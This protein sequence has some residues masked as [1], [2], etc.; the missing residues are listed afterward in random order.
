MI[1]NKNMG[2]VQKIPSDGQ[3]DERAGFPPSTLAFPYQY[4]STGAPWTSIY[5]SITDTIP[6]HQMTSLNNTLN[7]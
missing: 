2:Q 5:L 4:H 1:K 7:S 6:S 3:S